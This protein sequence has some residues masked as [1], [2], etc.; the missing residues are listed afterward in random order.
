MASPIFE[1]A[2]MLV[3]FDDIARVSVNANDGVVCAYQTLYRLERLY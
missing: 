1:I 2:L 3:R